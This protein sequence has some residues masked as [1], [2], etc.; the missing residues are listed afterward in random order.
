[1]AQSLLDYLEELP[2]KV[3]ELEDRRRFP[4]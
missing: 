4:P 1:M 2:V 3:K